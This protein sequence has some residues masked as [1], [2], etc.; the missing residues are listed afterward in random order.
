VDIKEYIESGILEAYALGALTEKERG[1]VDANVALYPEL[2]DELSAIEGAMQHF[3][4]AT[5]QDPPAYVQENIWDAIQQQSTVNETATAPRII[6][7]NSTDGTNNINWQRA[8]ILIALVGSMVVNF[9]LW[10]Q[11]NNAHDEQ[12]ALQQNID[13]LKKQQQNLALQVEH[14]NKLNEMTADTAMQTIVMQSMVKGHP[15]AATIYW[16]KGN[17]DAYLTANSLPMPPAGMQYQMW[18]I[19][20]GKPVSM[21]VLPNKI[22]DNTT[23]QKLAMNVK[24]GQAF[25]ISLEKEGG[26]PTPTQVYVLGK[27]SS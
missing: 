13:S 8:A 12:L 5:A 19:Q 9:I 27:V 4:E 17:G 2:A 10:S 6:P 24:T 25:A 11:R 18:V 14:F 16:S 7:L 3:V 20:D 23:M 26:N 1:E 22:V 15:M 21:G